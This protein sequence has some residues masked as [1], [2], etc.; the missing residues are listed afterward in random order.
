MFIGPALDLRISS[1]A[2]LTLNEAYP[3][4]PSHSY[5]E[6][7]SQLIGSEVSE[8]QR[9]SKKV[10]ELRMTIFVVKGRQIHDWKWH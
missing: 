10:H 5:T 1:A 8:G 7:M 4:P 6:Q 3:S 2:N 9:V